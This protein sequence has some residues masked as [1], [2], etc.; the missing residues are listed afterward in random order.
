[1]D[2]RIIVCAVVILSFAFIALLANTYLEIVPKKKYLPFS[3]EIVYNRYYALEQWLEKTGH[4]VRIE[5]EYNSSEIPDA[6]EKTAL[7]LAGAVN[8]KEADEYLLPWIMNGNS[9]VICINSIDYY[10]EDNNLMEFFRSFGIDAEETSFSPD[11]EQN[12]DDI[13]DFDMTIHL[14]IDENLYAGE[15]NIFLINDNHGFTRF[16]EISAGEG[17]LIVTGTPYFMYNNNLKK[18]INANLAWKLTGA[19]MAEENGGVLFV[20]SQYSRYIK[21][22]NS[23]LGKIMGKGNILPVCISAALI[24]LFGFWRVIPAFG[25]VLHEK[26][27]SSRPI[28]ER[29]SAEIM[30]FK[31]YKALGYY[32]EIYDRELQIDTNGEKE[33]GYKYEEL[34][35]KIRSVYDGTDKFKRGI[36]GFKVRTGKE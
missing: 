3:D 2:K 6:T 9:L 4:P 23:M 28:I 18:K 14:L 26:Q 22:S 12:E 17:K 13:P 34:L 36:S 21:M 10:N 20:R 29:F 35:N 32:L 24:I 31:K 5:T 15:E 27:R 16:V 30:F 8:W 33:K 19:Y 1:M 25:L 11:I 7:V